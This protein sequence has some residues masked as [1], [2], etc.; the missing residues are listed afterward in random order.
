MVGAATNYEPDL[1]SQKL[2]FKGEL[3]PKKQL[4]FKMILFHEKTKWYQQNIL[5]VYM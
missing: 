5:K 4:L 1:A 2:S 3:R